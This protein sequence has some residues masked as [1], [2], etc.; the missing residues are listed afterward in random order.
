MI[1]N[2][3]ILLYMRCLVIGT[4]SDWMFSDEM[5]SDGTFSDGTFGDWDV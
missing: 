5:F 3:L 1:W 2:I 4:L